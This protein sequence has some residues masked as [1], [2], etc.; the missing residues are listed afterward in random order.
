MKAL[1]Q[2]MDTTGCS[3][4]PNLVSSWRAPPLLVEF[5]PLTANENRD[6]IYDTLGFYAQD[7]WRMS[8]RVTWNLG[9][10]YEFMTTPYERT[11]HSS[12]LLNVFTDPFT[13]GPTLQNNSLHDFSPRVGVAWDVFGNGKTAVRAGF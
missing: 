7:D 13:I 5:E 2:I 8:S 6:Y 1:K 3:A 11:G 10:R 4:T 9:V 12:R